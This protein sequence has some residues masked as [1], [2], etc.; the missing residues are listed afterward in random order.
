MNLAWIAYKKNK[1][2]NPVLI[3]ELVMSSKEILNKSGIL[4]QI[5]LGHLQKHV[6]IH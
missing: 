6:F 5:L 2:K 1:K 3:K 4:C